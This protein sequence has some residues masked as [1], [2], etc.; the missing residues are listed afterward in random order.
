M[1]EV[2][3]DALEFIR[4]RL[5]HALEGRPDL[6][7][8]TQGVGLRLKFAQNRAYLS[9]AFPRTNDKVV[10]FMGRPLLIID[11]ADSPRLEGTC[12]TVQET[13][14]RSTLSILPRTHSAAS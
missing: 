7:R 12:L 1:L 6:R 8:S 3:E 4:A 5:E 10:S 14:G 11:P 13:S 9:L 2:S